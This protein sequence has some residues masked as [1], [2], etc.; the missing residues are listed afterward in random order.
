MKKQALSIS[1]VA[2]LLL[3]G[4]LVAVGTTATAAPAVKTL[5]KPQV[6]S[7]KNNGILIQYFET[8]FIWTAVTGPCAYTLTFEKQQPDKTWEPY[9]TK[10][11]V[12]TPYAPITISETGNFRWNVAATGPYAFLD[13]AP[14]NW[15]T[16]TVVPP[17]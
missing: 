4:V 8:T 7:P 6:I 5:A 2:L 10:Y 17:A 13:S 16:F 9:M 14:C 15:H 3:A 11:D 12:S 1:L